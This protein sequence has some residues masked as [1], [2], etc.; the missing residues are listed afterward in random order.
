MTK[1]I[2]I[3][4]SGKIGSGKDY[5]AKEIFLAK[6]KER[7]AIFNVKSLFLS[8]ADPLKQECS[9]RYNHSYEQ[10]YHNKDNDTRKHLQDVGNEFRDRFGENVYVNVMKMSITLHSE[11]SNIKIFI[12]PDV[13]FP[14]EMKFIQSIGGKVYRITAKNRSHDKLQQECKGDVN[15][16]ELRSQHVSENSL[17]NHEF[18]GYIHN[19]Y[20]DTTCE[21]EC[22][23]LAKDILH[24]FLKGVPRINDYKYLNEEETKTLRER[25]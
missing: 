13:R 14:N 6:L 25:E 15:E 8:F 9:L 12:I 7:G 22:E 2:V 20:D 4:F 17:D 11:R 23:L 5:I 19:D 16:M 1:S 18:D 10:L 24:L 3:G 21:K